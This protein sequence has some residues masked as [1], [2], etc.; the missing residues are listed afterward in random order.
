MRTGFSRASVVSAG[1]R[2]AM[3]RTQLG[4]EFGRAMGEGKAGSREG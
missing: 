1:R 2:W 3:G 4:I